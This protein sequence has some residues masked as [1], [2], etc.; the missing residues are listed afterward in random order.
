[1][2]RGAFFARLWLVLRLSCIVLI[3]TAVALLNATSLPLTMTE[4]SLMLRSGYSSDTVLREV[5]V[6][7][8]AG[9][10]DSAGEKQLRHAGA[11]EAL[12]AALRSGTY[13]AS[14]EEIAAVKQRTEIRDRQIRAPE[15]S[16]APEVN[17]SAATN[18]PSYVQTG[19][20]MYDHLKG[21]LVYLHNGG[22]VPFD[23]EVLERKK[24]YLLFLSAAWSKEGR[25]V[26]PLL[27]NYYNQAAPEHP[28]FEV[29]FFSA[30]RSAFGMEN[31]MTQSNMPWPAVAYEKLSGKAGALADSFRRQ[32]PRLVLVD[33]SGKVLSDSGEGEPNFG[34]VV[35]S[36]NKILATQSE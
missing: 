22:L 17:P 2:V 18:T 1:L 20:G 27:A 6:R 8:F 24:F 35:S 9:P 5:T 21:D 13:E 12:I 3:L 11:S 25:Q 14:S 4:L 16:A 10:L 32:I 15:V 34:K 33:A 31:Y 7:K 19:G 28:E 30:D 23:D 29:I 26:T 36:L